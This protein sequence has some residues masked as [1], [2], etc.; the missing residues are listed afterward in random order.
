MEFCHYYQIPFLEGNIPKSTR[1]AAKI[2]YKILQD[3]KQVS[4]RFRDSIVIQYLSSIPLDQID[5][6][7]N[8]NKIKDKWLTFF[9]GNQQK[10]EVDIERGLKNDF[11]DEMFEFI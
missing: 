1:D 6:K 10:L 8:P 4:D 11:S 9:K 2:Y 7:F 5:L 3:G